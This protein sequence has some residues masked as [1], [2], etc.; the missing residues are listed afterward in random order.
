M[1]G[2]VGTDGV[3][4]GGGVSV[5]GA[6]VG[7]GVWVGDGEA[8]C[9]TQPASAANTTIRQSGR[10][11]RRIYDSPSRNPHDGDLADLDGLFSCPIRQGHLDGEGD[12][13]APDVQRQP[14]F[15]PQRGI[16]D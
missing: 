4:V 5:G 11:M 2:K 8:A 1:A 3:A 14:G 10:N 13:V 15:I 6:S 12:Q 16:A 7:A 9:A